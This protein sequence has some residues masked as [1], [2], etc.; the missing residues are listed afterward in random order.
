[1][2][3]ISLTCGT[4]THH[5]KLMRILFSWF[6]CPVVFHPCF[7]PVVGRISRRHLDAFTVSTLSLKDH[8]TASRYKLLIDRPKDCDDKCILMTS[9][10]WYKSCFN[11][12]S[13]FYRFI[14]SSALS[15]LYCNEFGVKIQVK[16]APLV[17]WYWMDF[18]F[19]PLSA[20][21]HLLGSCCVTSVRDSTCPYG[22]AL[23]AVYNSKPHGLLCERTL[24]WPPVS[25]VSGCWEKCPYWLLLKKSSHQKLTE[26]GTRF[27]WASPTG[28][29]TT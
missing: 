6:V 1:M 16:S 28:F 17:V 25:F 11:I 15:C 21:T 5:L 29:F 22:V 18:R 13:L 23:K 27:F 8:E 2:V 4:S 26:R 10:S 7:S 12:K 9:M 19:G 24:S 3:L 14:L 20:L